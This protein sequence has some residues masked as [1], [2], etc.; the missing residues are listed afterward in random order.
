MIIFAPKLRNSRCS[1]ACTSTKRVSIAVAAAAATT[2]ASNAEVARPRRRTAARKSMR[3]NIDVCGPCERLAAR[4]RA[5]PELADV[6]G[7]VLIVRLAGQR[8]DQAARLGGSRR[9]CQRT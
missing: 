3:R 5:E 2:T 4:L 8:P 1:L 9:C 6:V 7:G